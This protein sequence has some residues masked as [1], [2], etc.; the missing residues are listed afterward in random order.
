MDVVALTAAV[1]GV[2]FLLLEATKRSVTAE[3]FAASVSSLSLP[4]AVA[5]AISSSLAAH[6]RVLL[7]CLSA[8]SLTLPHFA[9]LQW[10]LDVEVGRR[11]I[12]GRCEAMYLLELTVA[13]G[14]SSQGEQRLLL[15]SDYAALL[16]LEKE[17][18]AA[19]KGLQSKEARRILR[20]VK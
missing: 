13:G 8:A 10:R 11:S 18:E 16:Q 20:Y 14:S 6:S 19:V 7:A 5:A 9:D 3:D 4:P 2:G 1:H 15:Q 12:S 17:L